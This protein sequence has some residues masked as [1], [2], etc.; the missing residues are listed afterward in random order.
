MVY[1]VR[2]FPCE[3]EKLS[4]WTRTIAEVFLRKIQK[5]HFSPENRKPQELSNE[6]SCQYVKTILTILGNFCAPMVTDMTEV[7]IL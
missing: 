6:W 7:T 5:M 3:K 2:I 4:L 1:E